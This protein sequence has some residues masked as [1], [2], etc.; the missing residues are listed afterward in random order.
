MLSRAELALVYIMWIVATAIPE[1]GFTSFLLPDITGV[2]YYASPE[3]E[4]S[5]LLL[6]H[7]PQWI[8]PFREFNEVQDFYEGA[9]LGQG[10]S[11]GDVVGRHCSTGSPSSPPCTWP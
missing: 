6:P 4:W 10:N 5:K 11:V 8:M 3:N 9:P 2:V 1:W 7:I